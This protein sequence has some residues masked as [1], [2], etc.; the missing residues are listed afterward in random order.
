M[1]KYQIVI[2][3]IVRFEDRY[4]IVQRWYDDRIEDPYQWEFIDG[5]IDFGEAPDRAVV[6]LIRE[7]TGLETLIDRIA[8]TWSYMVGDVHHIG[9]SYECMALSDDVVLSEELH[10]HRLSRRKNLKIILRT[11][12]CWMISNVRSISEEPDL[13]EKTSRRK[14]P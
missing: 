12:R 4:L 14:Q 6:R 7:Q 1:E 13:P 2:K 11:G 9:I 10:D 3:G 5:R 8:Y